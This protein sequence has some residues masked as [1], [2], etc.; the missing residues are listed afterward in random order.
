MPNDSREN[1]MTKEEVLEQL[2]NNQVTDL[3]SLADL[4]VREANEDGDPAK[5]LSSHVI[6]YTHGFVTS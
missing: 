5:P 3:D 1:A 6:I 4:I 2:K